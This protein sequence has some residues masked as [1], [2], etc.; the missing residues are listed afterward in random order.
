MSLLLDWHRASL[1]GANAMNRRR[2]VGE[3]EFSPYANKAHFGGLDS[4]PGDPLMSIEFQSVE[5]P[6]NRSGIAELSNQRN[7]SAQD[8][9]YHTGYWNHDQP[10]IWNIFPHSKVSWNQ[11]D[12]NGAA[13]FGK[14]PLR[15]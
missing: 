15:K 7:N 11:V 8:A 2:S 3:S 9:G 1:V 5:A 13:I 6:C 14:Q 12:G 4:L 10:V